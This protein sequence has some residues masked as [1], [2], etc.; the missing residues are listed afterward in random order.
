ML[1]GVF[2]YLQ[3][4]SAVGS[5][6]YKYCFLCWWT[7]KWD[8]WPYHI[9]CQNGF[10]HNSLW[11]YI[12]RITY[13][14]SK[15]CTNY[16][17]YYQLLRDSNIG[18]MDKICKSCNRLLHYQTFGGVY[19]SISQSKYGFPKSL[20]YWLIR[21]FYWR[22][23]VVYVADY[24]RRTKCRNAVHIHVSPNFVGRSGRH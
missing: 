15:W 24:H 9:S 8:Y 1:F 19:L 20:W 18:S 6:R 7:T 12:S 5:F 13:Q 10:R 3:W 17:R 2:Y 22:L 11:Y 21:N 14:C 4:I 16:L 23:I